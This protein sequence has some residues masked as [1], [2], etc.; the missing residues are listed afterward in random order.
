MDFWQAV[1]TC[2]SKYATFGGRAARSEYWF[3]TLF[4]FLVGVVLA[5]IDQAL[6]VEEVLSGI[7]GLAILVPSVAVA[8]RRLHDTD[9]TGWWYLLILAPVVGVI[10]LIVFFATKGTEGPNRFGPD[11]LAALPGGMQPAV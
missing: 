6:D 1:R 7:F 8:V 9:R 5:F 10:V 3:F 2:F 4:T 11:P